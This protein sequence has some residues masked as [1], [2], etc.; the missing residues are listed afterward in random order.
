[1]ANVA[2]RFGMK[3]LTIAVGVP[4]GI[5]AKKA[6]AR[7]F[8]VARPDYTPREPNQ[9]DVQ[10]ADAIGYAAL[11]AAGAVA[12]KLITRKGAE[13]AWRALTGS[14]PPPPPLTQEEKR[15]AKAAEKEAK[16]AKAAARA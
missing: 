3:I 11:A 1:M 6:V 2:G 13:S 5:A 15:M 8:T 4:V 7:A 9:R 10:W 12:A 16:A 14:E